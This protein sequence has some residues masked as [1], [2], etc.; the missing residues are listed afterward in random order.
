MLIAGVVLQQSATGIAEDSFL[1]TVMDFLD[2]PAPYSPFSEYLLVLFILWLIAR[3]H[4]NTRDKSMDRQ[5]QEVLDEKFA[6]G[7]LS[8]K[9]Y[10]KFRQDVTRN[11][12]KR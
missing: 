10:E 11:R 5:A 12:P 4:R 8:Q 7:E 9:A 6:D 3:L 2:T 1:W